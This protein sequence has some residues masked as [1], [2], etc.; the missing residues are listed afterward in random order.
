MLDSLALE[1][2]L[3][4]GLPILSRPIPHYLGKHYAFVYS[5]VTHF[6]GK[7]DEVYA[8]Y[9]ASRL[10]TENYLTSTALIIK[11]VY[12]KM[13]GMC[14][15]SNVKY[16]E[17]Y[18]FWLRLQS[19]GYQGKLLREPLFK[20]RRHGFGQSQSLTSGV[21]EDEW[22]NEL[23]R[24]NPVAY[25]DLSTKVLC[26]LLD[27]DSQ[28]KERFLPCYGPVR[29][30]SEPSLREKA[31]SWIRPSSPEPKSLVCSSHTMQDFSIKDIPILTSKKDTHKISVLYMIPWMVM[32][33]A[34]LY[35]LQVL[36]A[37]RSAQSPF[38]YRVTLLVARH[39]EVHQ[40][41]PRF[42]KLVDEV[43]HLQRLTND[44]L[45]EDQI[46]DY[47]VKSRDAQFVINSRTVAGY[48]AFE[49]WNL[50]DDFKR[51][52]KMDILHLQEKDSK[53]GWEWRAGRIHTTMAARVVV[54]ENLKEYLSNT[55]GYGR[56]SLGE[57]TV[58][59]QALSPK[60]R[61]RINV[62]YPPLDLRSFVHRSRCHD[63][64]LC[65]LGTADDPTLLFIGRLDSQKMPLLF[66]DVANRTRAEV[67]VRMVGSGPLGSA[68]K[69]FIQNSDNVHGLRKR[70]HFTGSL[71]Q[72]DIPDQLVLSSRSVFLL[73]SSYEGV[74]IVV[75]EALGVGT[76]VITTVCGGISEVVKDSVWDSNVELT[77]VLV[78]TTTF[79]IERLPYASLIHINC[80]SLSRA[81]NDPYY[82][83][84]ISSLFS[85]EAHYLLD[86]MTEE[87]QEIGY[88]DAQARRWERA[89]GFRDKYSSQNFQNRWKT[90]IDSLVSSYSV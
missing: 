2:L 83:S 21:S 71:P 30:V 78:G 23:R 9:D 75:L 41:A 64:S 28:K 39:I 86:R 40:W 81:T 27:Q 26:Q 32:G 61:E 43:F 63:A 3:L 87:G 60:D 57:S 77:K 88:R 66:L 54:S 45:V 34:D 33:G 89:S 82:L 53:A 24:N 46:L 76:P 55:V 16:F 14:P 56:A 74:P 37:L 85:N 4:F 90:R 80:E 38:Q 17:D 65:N 19:F 22:R 36:E 10:L 11:D 52:K 35:D 69:H 13:G 59:T 62:I 31:M 29:V 48:R 15:R 44:S 5:G 79:E 84:T 50:M 1:K 70:I 51:I 7:S 47:L 25:R 18:D 20:Y 6:G 58:E 49:R 68:I 67:R 73:T 8:D 42:L 72:E 12:V